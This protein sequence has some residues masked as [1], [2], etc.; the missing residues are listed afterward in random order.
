VRESKWR[1]FQ[2]KDYLNCDDYTEEEM[3]VIADWENAPKEKRDAMIKKCGWEATGLL[4]QTR[5]PA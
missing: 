3:A 5:A 2:G 4:F 1:T